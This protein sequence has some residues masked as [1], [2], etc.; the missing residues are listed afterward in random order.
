MLHPRL[1]ILTSRIIIQWSLQ[2]DGKD[3]FR[4]DGNNY[5]PE[6]GHTL[7]EGQDKIDINQCWLR[8]ERQ[9]LR[10]LEETKAIVFCVRL[11]MTSLHDIVKEGNGV[12]LA[13]AINSMPEKL[14]N[15]KKR[16]FWERDVMK[17][18]RQEI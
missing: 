1:I 17:Y 5:Y 3:L 11:Y 16:P 9:T 6:K 4:L 18:L 8:Y 13:D 2:V 12:E 7:P 10:V 14:G 15:Y